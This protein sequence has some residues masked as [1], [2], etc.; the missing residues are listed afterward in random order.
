MKALR[1]T[2]LSFGLVWLVA[3]I[4]SAQAPDTSDI[5]VFPARQKYKHRHKIRE[6][7]D[8]FTDTLSVELSMSIGGGSSGFM[9]GLSRLSHSI[10]MSGFVFKGTLTAQGQPPKTPPAEALF[11]FEFNDLLREDLSGS[12]SETVSLILDGS[13]RLSIDAPLKHRGQNDPEIDLWQEHYT[14]HVPLRELLRIVAAQKVEGRIRGKTFEITDDRLLALRDFASRAAPDPA[15]GPVLLSELEERGTRH[16][17]EALTS[18]PASAAEALEHAVRAGWG[19]VVPGGGHA[20]R[21]ADATLRPAGFLRLKDEA[22][23]AIYH[24]AMQAD[25]T[26]EAPIAA[27]GDT[28]WVIGVESGESFG[29]PVAARRRV[30]PDNSVEG[31]YINKTGWAYLLELDAATAMATASG[32]FTVLSTRF[33]AQKIVP[34]PEAV[35]E[36]LRPVYQQELEEAVQRVAKQYSRQMDISSIR[37]SMYGEDSL[38]ALG[39]ARSATLRGPEGPVHLISASLRDDISDHGL[40]TYVTYIVDAQGKVLRRVEGHYTPLAAGDVDGD[41]IDELVTGSGII[42]WD[43]H[44]WQFPPAQ[45]P[46]G[47]CN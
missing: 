5:A 16:A 7:Y 31:A 34:A 19:E 33:P 20:P 35:M 37:A 4:A 43:G 26:H 1:T 13:D 47:K 42:R 9:K 10:G 38:G 29:V 36:G 39:Y 22:R 32:W 8:R 25:C 28:M 45:A 21:V 15:A 46:G 12:R 41:G 27:I 24:L 40:D 44:A 23:N 18:S 2:L 17:D 11:T 6:D 30:R 14:A 3:P